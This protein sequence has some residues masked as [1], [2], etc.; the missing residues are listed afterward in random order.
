MTELTVCMD[1]SDLSCP[2]C[3][4][5]LFNPVVAMD[6]LLYC[7]KCIIEWFLTNSHCPNGLNNGTKKQWVK[8]NFLT[9]M[10]KLANPLGCMTIDD[11]VVLS[12]DSV[13]VD[14]L[15]RKK[16]NCENLI[17]V[18]GGYDYLKIE[19]GDDKLKQIFSN[20]KLVKYLIKNVDAEWAGKCGSRKL[21]HYVCRFASL[22]LIKY[23][24]R[25]KKWDLETMTGKDWRPIHYACSCSNVLNSSDQMKMIRYLVERGVDLEAKN[26]EG[27]RPIHFVCGSVTNLCSSDQVEMI[28]YLAERGVCLEEKDREDWKPIHYVCSCENNLCST[29]QAEMIRYMM[30][31]KVCMESVNDEGICPQHIVFSGNNYLSSSDYLS[32]AIH[33]MDRKIDLTIKDN[34]GLT[35][36]DY[37]YETNK[38]RDDDFLKLWEYMTGNGHKFDISKF[39]SKSPYSPTTQFE[40]FMELDDYMIM[41]YTINP[42][43]L[44]EC[45]FFKF[46]N[47]TVHI[48]QKYRNIVS[49][50]LVMSLISLMDGSIMQRV[51]KFMKC[52]GNNKVI[53]R[54][55]K[56]TYYHIV[57][58]LIN[59]IIL[60]STI[61]DDLQ[62]IF[63]IV[64]QDIRSTK[65][66]SDSD[67]NK[68]KKRINF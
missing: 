47:E 28:R 25:L 11:L 44:T 32:I 68:I 65:Y 50:M 40:I 36:I 56:T 30:D 13:A 6:G 18:I 34:M 1:R 37:L 46:I 5:D 27:M 39:L 26:N 41:E 15:C 48:N 35:P 23:A 14:M 21:I 58:S 43:D 61:E 66:I 19:D 49:D 55:S 33:M 42:D 57:Y 63:S 51:Q 22:K 2:I 4:D 7:E 29:D 54:I 24:I 16:R 8:C 10:Y 62:E 64:M 59:G 67:F 31:R 38:L 20:K 60:V 12:T 3:M 9:D 45:C 52:I 17:D 53:K